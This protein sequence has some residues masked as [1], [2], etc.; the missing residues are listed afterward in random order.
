MLFVLKLC[1]C[2][3]EWRNSGVCCCGK[4]R[5]LVKFQQT[6]RE[7][8][9]LLSPLR[10]HKL[11]CFTHI[12]RFRK[13]NRTGQENDTSLAEKGI[14]LPI[15]SWPYRYCY[16]SSRLHKF[17]ESRQ[18]KMVRFSALVTGRLYSQMINLALVSISGWV[19]R[20]IVVRPEGFCHWKIPIA[21]Q[22]I[23]TATLRLVA[24]Y[25]D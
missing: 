2:C 18:M 11:F 13:K 20:R 23:E 7:G 8:W 12:H 22:G 21:P 6:A 5:G 1:P 25:L 14:A 15:Q 10:K 4:S 3:S 19:D 24:Q 17:L 9:T 16:R